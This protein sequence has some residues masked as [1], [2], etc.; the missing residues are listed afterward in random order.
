MIAFVD[1]KHTPVGDRFELHIGRQSSGATQGTVVSSVAVKP[2]HAHAHASQLVCLPA[3][4]LYY[5]QKV[6]GPEL[7]TCGT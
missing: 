3:A 7:V 2:L 4:H 5:P 6:S 1:H